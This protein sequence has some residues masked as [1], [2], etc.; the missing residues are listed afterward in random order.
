MS[1]RDPRSEWCPI[2]EATEEDKERATLLLWEGFGF[3]GSWQDGHDGYMSGRRR[4][5]PLK[6]M[7]IKDGEGQECHPTHFRYMPEGPDT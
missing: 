6:G 3:T 2:D 5:P 4:V 7:W 1:Q